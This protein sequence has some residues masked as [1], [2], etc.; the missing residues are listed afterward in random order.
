VTLINDRAHDAIET[1]RR[2]ENAF[3]AALEVDDDANGDAANEALQRAYSTVPTSPT[4]VAALA[5]LALDCEGDI[6]PAIADALRSIEAAALRLAG[7]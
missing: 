7:N 5:R 4:G 6:E 1:A 3:V 2:A